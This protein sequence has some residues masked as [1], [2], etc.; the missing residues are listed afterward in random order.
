MHRII[1]LH[2]ILLHNAMSTRMVVFQCLYQWLCHQGYICILISMVTNNAGDVGKNGGT[3]N[4][5]R[6]TYSSQVVILVLDNCSSSSLVLAL[7]GSHHQELWV[8]RPG[9]PGPSKTSTPL[10]LFEQGSCEFCVA[11]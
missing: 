7:Q 3:K 5:T 8:I 9:M 2:L 6:F 1:S 10:L 11:G 4:L